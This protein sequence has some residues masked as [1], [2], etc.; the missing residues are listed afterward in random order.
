MFQL[1]ATRHA[2]RPSGVVLCGGLIAPKWSCLLCVPSIPCFCVSVEL[3][4]PPPGVLALY[5]SL[6]V[7]RLMIDGLAL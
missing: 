3:S 1:H 2:S 5:Y 6:C 4:F 7:C